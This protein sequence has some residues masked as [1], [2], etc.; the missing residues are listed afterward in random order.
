M[1]AG[2]QGLETSRSAFISF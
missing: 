2:I 1:F